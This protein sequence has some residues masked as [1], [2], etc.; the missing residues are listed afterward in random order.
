MGEV[1]RA[2]DPQLDR[3]VAIKVL[4]DFS[5]DPDRL[6]RFELEARATAALSHPNILAV[7]QLGTYESAPYLVSELLDGETLREQIRRSGHLSVR[8]TTD[9]GVQI[10]RGLA[11][12]HEKGVVHRDLKPE[13]LF[14]V[15]DGRVKILDFGLAKLVQPH[16]SADLSGAT[17]TLS[18]EPGMVMGTVGY[19]S[20]EQVR[21]QDTDHRTDIFAFGA[22]LYEMLAGNRAFQKP[23]SAETMAAILNDE[24]T[25][26]SQLT[27]SL[28]LAFVRII[29]RCLEKNPERRFQS[30]SDLA[31]AL[32]ALSDSGSGSAASPSR[33]AAR[34]V[35]QWI[36]ASLLISAMIA[37]SVAW[38]AA[39]P[40]TPT[41]KA[42]VQLTDD[43]E[44]KPL[45]RLVTDGSRI[46]FNEG[47]PG[48]LRIAQVSANGGQTASIATRLVNPQITALSPDG[49]SL[50][51]LV[52]GFNDWVSPLWSIPLPAGEPRRLGD[53][54]AQDANF[55]PDGRIVFTQGSQLFAADK[56]GSNPRKL[57]DFPRYVLAPS[58]SPD[59]KRMSVTISSGV[60][61]RSR[62]VEFAA[63]NPAKGESAEIAKDLT[64]PGIGAWTR[65]AKYLLFANFGLRSDLWTFPERSGFLQWPGTPVRLTNGP[66]SYTAAIP[67]PTGKQVFAVG[68]KQRGEFVRYDEKFRQFVPFLPG[69]SATDAT[70]SRDGKWSA[71]RAYP[72][73]TLWRS[74]ADGTERLQLTYSPTLIWLPAISPDGTKVVYGTT[75][76]DVYVISME[77]GTPR[78]IASRAVAA[79]W[80]PDGNQL[81]ITAFPSQPA[82]DTF[83]LELHIMDLQSGKTTIVPNSQD[84]I[85]AFWIDQHTLVASTQDTTKFLIL[86]LTT[87]KWSELD[88]GAFVNWMISP[89][90]KFLY[91]TTGGEEPKVQRIR[92]SDRKIETIASLKGIRRVIDPYFG[93]QLGVTPDGSILLARD[94]GTQEIYALDVTWP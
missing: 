62:L 14:I 34:P 51:A 77:G 66:L 63:D 93:T 61:T 91:F 24:P 67:S 4:P 75:E 46:Y 88:S 35:W 85:G 73:Y 47:P 72:T 11:A 25:E 12:A 87:N 78:K 84:R 21:G 37:G 39:S 76:H 15:R 59:G 19:M 50:L 44:P 30:A 52:G 92:F 3:D 60:L 45:H 18:T 8:K 83:L 43:G 86:D 10:A 80:S 20:P 54:R 56:D 2:R 70:F 79:T 81:A 5:A 27:P 64:S 17:Q 55:F 26:I 71:Y 90:S 89:D 58:V 57:L 53:I 29:H 16:E 33:S 42:V 7:F 28:P 9:Y 94:L 49:S 40:A 36:A 41:V 32:E 31:F 1:Y 6:R 38:H 68:S 69:L 48:S 13:N 23:T 74:H 22:I 82:A 65:D